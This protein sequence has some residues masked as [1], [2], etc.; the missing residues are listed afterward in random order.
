MADEQERP[1]DADYPEMYKKKMQELQKQ[2]EQEAELRA[3][4]KAI[5]E[6][7][8]YE[9][10]SNIRL[11]NPEFFMKIAQLLVYLY[12]QGKI[13]NKVDEQTLKALVSKVLGSKKQGTIT[14]ERK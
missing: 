6:P 4:L 5:L 14:F 2:Q 1:Q 3:A 8:A 10:L 7:S 13:K 12:K 9:R 11:S